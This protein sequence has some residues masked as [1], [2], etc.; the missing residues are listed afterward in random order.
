MS[1]NESIDLTTGLPGGKAESY[2]PQREVDSLRR[3]FESGGEKDPVPKA[4]EE[5]ERPQ[6]VVKEV[7]GYEVLSSPVCT[8]KGDVLHWVGVLDGVHLEGVFE[9]PEAVAKKAKEA[10]EA[11]ELPKREVTKPKE[12]RVRGRIR[13]TRQRMDEIHR[14]TRAAQV[15][16]GA[17]QQWLSLQISRAVG[18]LGSGLSPQDAASLE[19]AVWQAAL[20]GRL[21][22]GTPSDATA[23]AIGDL[24]R[25][26]ASSMTR[27][28]PVPPAPMPTDAAQELPDIGIDADLEAEIEK[29]LAA[30]MEGAL[31]R[32]RLLGPKALQE[33]SRT[34]R[35]VGLSPPEQQDA[36]DIL[37]QSG[38]AFQEGGGG[39]L[40]FES[41]EDAAQARVLLRRLPSMRPHY[42]MRKRA[43]VGMEAHA[44]EAGGEMEEESLLSRAVDAALA[45]GLDAGVEMLL[46]ASPGPKKRPAKRPYYVITAEQRGAKDGKNAAGWWEQD[47]IGGRVS[48]RVDTKDVARRV[49]QAIEDGDPQVLDGLAEMQPRGAELESV[50]SELADDFPD[51]DRDDLEAEYLQAFT[52]ALENEVARMC[53]EHLKEE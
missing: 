38:I 37:H 53:R 48:S 36:L 29:G 41:E 2:L 21:G 17:V 14:S 19:D 46:D 32:S 51:K 1:E 10:I 13:L 16:E 30:D 9:S 18:D 11:A 28:A 8:P 6:P 7:Q 24:V 44:Q 27:S 52:D 20:A 50:V 42:K 47:A 25:E 3:L 15:R 49:L 40:E 31:K 33:S 23:K 39:I 5:K 43:G 35:L 45:K 34:I 22:D 26:L 4:P 12:S